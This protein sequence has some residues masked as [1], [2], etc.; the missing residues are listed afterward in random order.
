ME[1][2]LI[3]GGAGFIGSHLAQ[4]LLEEGFNV[5]SIDNLSTGNISNIDSLRESYPKKFTHVT[6]TIEKEESLVAEL[7]DRSD[8][9]FHLAA[10]VGVKLVVDEPTKTL[11]TN[12]LG[13]EIILKHASKKGKRVILASTSEVYGKNGFK[14]PLKESYDSVIG[15]TNKSR[16]GYAVSKLY[17]EHLAL[18]YFKEKSLPVTIVRFFNITGPKQ[19]GRY[20]MVLPRFIQSALTNS[21]LEVYGDGKQKRCFCYVEDAIEA[22]IKIIHLKESI[23]EIYNIGN[24][25][26]ISIAELAEKVKKSV[27]SSSEIVYIPYSIAYGEGFEDMD[28]RVPDITK[29]NNLMGWSSKTPLDAIIK[30]T[31]EWLKE[32]LNLTKL[33]TP[34]I[35]GSR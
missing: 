30:S 9:I 29:I 15:P 21:K 7:I 22:L 31:T 12:T 28:R 26:E 16:W 18:A 1:S 14:G 20:G 11:E 6:A 32:S 2:C 17:D 3:T 4:K 35:I 25:E 33:S 10:A 23:G 19:V 8:I 13:T 27:G 34:K 24:P 5:Y